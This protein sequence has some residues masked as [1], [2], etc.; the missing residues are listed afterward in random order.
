MKRIVICFLLILSY[1]YGFADFET[2]KSEKRIKK[3]IDTLTYNVYRG[4]I[5]D[6]KTRERLNFVSVIAKGTNIATVSN[7]EGEFL[8]KIAKNITADSLEISHIGYKN[9]QISCKQLYKK[10][11]I[12]RLIPVEIALGEVAVYPLDAKKIVQGILKNKRV[13][14]PQIPN[15]LEGFYRESVRKNRKYV[16][17]SEAV[18]NIYKSAYNHGKTDQ[19]RIYKGRKSRDVKRM[20]TLLFK[21]QGGPFMALQLDMVRNPQVIFSPSAIN[22]Y[23][24]KLRTITTINGRLHFVIDFKQKKEIELPLYRGVL[25]IES[26]NFALTGAKFSVNMENVDEVRRMF[27]RRKPRGVKITPLIAEYMVNYRE[28]GGTWYFV[29]SR[30]YLKFKCNWKRKLF[31]SNYMVTT[32]LAI[33]DRDTANVVRFK[34]KERFKRNQV[35]VDKVDDFQDIDFWGSHNTIEPEQSIEAAIRKIKRRVR[36]EK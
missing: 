33:T 28:K 15:K 8:L 31:N 21:L 34:P 17:I 4:K 16:A 27:V 3:H 35:M 24:F 20:D 9:L 26:D 23:D 25:Y 1:G 30:A 10:R 12:I 13:N 14:Y 18:V 11:N 32:E 19:I 29:Y 7:S 22:D 2:I 6:A 5:I 36:R